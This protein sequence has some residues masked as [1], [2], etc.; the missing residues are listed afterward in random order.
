MSQQVKY[1]STKRILTLERGKPGSCE[2]H[3]YETI[4]DL[5]N[6]KTWHHI[7][8]EGGN[9]LYKCDN[10]NLERIYKIITII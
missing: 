2:K 8:I 6:S 10:C 5:E 7:E 9:L 1:F 4:F 3:K